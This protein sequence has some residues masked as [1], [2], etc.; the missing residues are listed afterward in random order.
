ML[1]TC[2]IASLFALTIQSTVF[3]EDMTTTPE[4][5]REFVKLMVGRWTGEPTL[6]RDDPITGVKAGQKGRA[7]VT[8]STILDGLG[9]I[10][11]NTGGANAGADMGIYDKGS[12]QFKVMGGST[13]GGFFEAIIWKQESGK[14]K[15][16]ATGTTPEGEKA[17]YKAAFQFNGKG[18]ELTVTLEI[19]AEGNESIKL[20]NKSIRLDK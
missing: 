18:T 16:I 20:E 10:T 19:A 1:R 14:W 11:R 17:K 9:F 7:Y 13:D 8:R 5:A 6:T 4:E 3:A 12:K 15:A 2:A